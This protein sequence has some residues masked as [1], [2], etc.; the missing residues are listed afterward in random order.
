MAERLLS[1]QHYAAVV[2]ADTR[3]S[4]AGPSSGAPSSAVNAGRG[5][6][7]STS[8]STVQPLTSALTLQSASSSSVERWA[9]GKAAQVSSQPGVT[10]RQRRRAAWRFVSKE[11]QGWAR[12]KQQLASRG[13]RKR[14]R[15]QAR[16]AAG[17][18]GQEAECILDTMN[19]LELAKLAWA[20][21]KVG[22]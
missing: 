18:T 3:I 13:A 14:K 4:G 5:N 12:L 17:V 16:G 6:A 11:R 22:Y 20:Y 9:S 8:T 7:S 21:A 2:A 19:E 15:R 10:R 1:E